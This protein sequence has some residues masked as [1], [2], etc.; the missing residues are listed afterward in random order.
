MSSSEENVYVTKTFLPPRNE[1]NKYVDRIWDSGQLTNNG[2]LSKEFCVRVC[3]YLDIDES[4]FLFTTNGTLALQLAVDRLINQDVGAEIITTPF[5][6]VATSSAILWQKHTPVFV[7]IEPRCFT[8]DPSKIEDA[9]TEKTKAILAVHVF[10]KPCDVE[11][12]EKIA[13]KYNLKVIYDAAHAFGVTYKGKSILEYGDAS[14]LS[15]HATKLMHTI[16]GGAVYVRSKMDANNIDLSRRFGHNGDTHLQLGINAKP[17]E[18]QAAM[19]LA[20][21]P[22]ID[23]IISHRELVSELYDDSLSSLYQVLPTL[24]YVQHNYSYYPIVFKSETELLSSFEKLSAEGIFPRRYFYPSLNTLPY[25][26]T[27]YSCPVSEDISSRI[28]C[29]PLDAQIDIEVVKKICKIL[30][31]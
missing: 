14:I 2:N 18:F 26:T 16:E 13:K 21:L 4:K 28:A 8:I 23:E 31:Q 7:D 24:S 1:F 10:G 22:Y 30:T 5:T 6:Y 25:L 19:G 3:E 20:V 15:F 12:I 9:I 27:S 11:A 17:S 29:L